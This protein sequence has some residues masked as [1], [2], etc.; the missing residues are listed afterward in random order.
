MPNQLS[1]GIRA[2]RFIISILCL[3]ILSSCGGN[4]KPETT[5]SI[6]EIVPQE[7]AGWKPEGAAETYDRETIFDYI[8]GAGEVYLSYGFRKVL[9][10]RY[11]KPDAPG[12]VVEIFDMG[13]SEDAYGVFSHARESE[14]TGI[15]QGYEYRGSLLCF[16]KGEYYVCV[17]AEKGTSETKEV[18]FA[19]SK[20]IAGKLPSTGDKPD[21]L[22][23]L[24]QEN[25]V[26]H[27]VRFFHIHPLLNYHYFLSEEN[28]LNL[29]QDTK[30]ALAVYE[31]DATY[32]LCIQYPTTGLAGEAYRG[33]VENY[34]PEAKSV[35]MAQ[36]ENG[37]WVAARYEKEYVVI[38][39]DAASKDK[40]KKLINACLENISKATP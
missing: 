2:K 22:K 38:S 32:L 3:V 5:L 13:V 23:Y 24:P 16:W 15:G 30:A 14:E 33:F 7:T 35:G 40:A 1:G 29:N 4:E 10:F 11:S 28:I 20:R 19:V 26:S 37:K 6:S 25:L 31:P 17:L 27:S 8:N 18:V 21:L 12:I 9:V 36:V 34:I 39:L